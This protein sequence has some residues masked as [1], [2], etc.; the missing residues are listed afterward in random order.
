VLCLGQVWAQTPP[1]HPENPRRHD[2]KAKASALTEQMFPS[3][4][5]AAGAVARRNF[6]DEFIFEKMARDRVPHAALS[7]DEEFFRRVH[8][9]LIGRMPDHKDLEQ[10]RA[11]A[12]PD[13]RARLI[14]EL[15]KTPAF[16]AKWT[17]WF[18]D[19]SKTAANRVGP[20]GKNVYYNWVYDNLHL[21]RPYGEM[22][23]DLLTANAVSNWNTGPA[24]YVARWVVIGLACDDEVHEDTA[25]E[26]AINS[27]RHFWGINLTC[28]SCHDGANHLEKINVWLSQ[29]KRDELYKMAAFFGGTRVL[30]RTEIAVT[31]DEYSID[32]LG[33][34]YDASARTVVRVPR[35]GKG[36]V[37]PEFMIT[38]DRADMSRPLRPQYARMLTGHPQFARATVNLV[39]SEFF[40]AGIVEPV[41]DFD[42]ARQDPKSLPAGWEAQPSHPE[43]LDALAE[44]FR[45]SGYNLQRLFETIANSSAYQLSSRFQGEWKDAYAKYFARKLV[46]RLKAE[47]IHDSIVHATGIGT[48]IPIRGTDTMAKFATETRSPEDFKNRDVPGLKDA[49]FFLES[50]G[51]TNREYSERTNDGDIT[52]AILLMN[53]PFVLRQTRAAPGSFLSRLLSEEGAQREDRIR[54]LFQRFLVRPPS[55]E[56]LSLARD[57]VASSEAG[58]EDLQW[59][60]V[61]KVEF[62]FNY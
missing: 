34:G 50:F 41:F 4:P 35:K 27:V 6:I 8:L 25:D 28:V 62:L 37:L 54:T 43:L 3:R 36:K 1:G 32:D 38:G 23:Q 17:Y 48:A 42:L 5:G 55:P 59:L 13:K 9:D 12:S 20:G 40:G 30:R 18:M 49:N 19:L 29:R 22:V 47:E 15:M 10:F 51:Q 24:S 56:E 46:R 14:R 45:K 11:D 60:L 39:W 21:N 16:K 33:Q 61:N 44:D 31:R 57:I 7:G 26:L 2:A 53:S 58:W 52:Q